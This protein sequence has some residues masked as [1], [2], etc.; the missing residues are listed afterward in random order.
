MPAPHWEA[1]A[2][3]STPPALWVVTTSQLSLDGCGTAQ[4]LAQGHWALWGRS[5]GTGLGGY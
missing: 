2:L 1:A 5:T 3:L 4:R